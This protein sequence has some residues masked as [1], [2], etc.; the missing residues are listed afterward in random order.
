MKTIGLI[1]GL[2]WESTALYY[3]HL[4][5]M[6]RERLGGLYSAPIILWSFDFAQVEAMQASGDWTGATAAMADAGRRLA[7]AGAD[8]IVICSNTMHRMAGAVEDAAGVPLIH[9]ADATAEAVRREGSAAPLL[10]ATRFTME[11][12]FYRGRMRDRHGLDVRVPGDADRAKVHDVIYEELCRGVIDRGSKAAYLEI[13]DRGV[14]AGADGVIL[15]CTEVGLLIGAD[16]LGLPVFDSTR[17]HAEAALDA[18]LG[19]HVGSEG[20]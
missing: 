3:A 2:S 8:L 11:G 7:T 4:N 19:T 18:A 15:G 1:G 10:L 12:A 17:I 6:T 13:V 14:E 9:I 20:D 16:D 5:R